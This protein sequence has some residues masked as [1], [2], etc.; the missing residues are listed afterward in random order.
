[1]LHDGDR[2]VAPHE[3]LQTRVLPEYRAELLEEL[4]HEFFGHE[5]LNRPGEPAAVYPCRRLLIR[6]DFFGQRERER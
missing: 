2:A 6:E 5:R 4:L 1:M 3:Q